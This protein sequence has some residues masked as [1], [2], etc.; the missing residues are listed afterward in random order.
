MFTLAWLHLGE[1]VASIWANLWGAMFGGDPVDLS[2]GLFVLTKTDLAMADVLPVTFT[3]TYRPN[4]TVSRSF[5]IGAAHSYSLVLYWEN[6]YSTIALILPGGERVRYQRTSP[7]G[8][9]ADA[10]LEHTETP[11]PFYKSV[12]R[13]VGLPATGSRRWWIRSRGRSRWATTAWTGY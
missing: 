8:G 3:R 4:D 1:L 6:W 9:W 10:V 5:G 13:F 12:L 11:S 2:T 7:G